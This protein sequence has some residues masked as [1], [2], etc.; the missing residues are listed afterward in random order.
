MPAS[1]KATATRATAAPGRDIGARGS[2]GTQRSQVRQALRSPSAAERPGEDM[3]ADSRRFDP[4]RQT[5]LGT[6]HLASVYFYTHDYDLGPEETRVLTEVADALVA[7]IDWPAFQRH[8]IRPILRGRVE[9]HADIRPARDPD[10][11]DLAR[12]RALETGRYLVGRM[13]IA[14][15]P[16]AIVPELDIVGKGTL[17]CRLDERCRALEPEALAATR[18]ADV[19]A[20][21]SAPPGG[22]PTVLPEAGE[23]L[24]VGLAAEWREVVEMMRRE[25]FTDDMI[26]ALVRE[27]GSLD[28]ADDILGLINVFRDFL[29][30]AADL[31]SV[32]GALVSLLTAWDKALI[33]KQ[34]VLAPIS[35][36]GVAY[37]VTAWA[38]DRAHPVDLPASDEAEIRAMGKPHYLDDAREIWSNSASRG[39]LAF[40]AFYAEANKTFQDYRRARGREAS[41]LPVA[42]FKALIRGMFGNDP[43][44]MACSFFDSMV[45][46]AAFLP[47]SREEEYKLRVS[48]EFPN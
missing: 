13:E 23:G 35:F 22:P 19:Y 48:C 21:I 33:G 25:G 20:E 4:R 40:A 2:S 11:E 46:D 1:V 30:F 15:G 6:N 10:N 36:K 7:G 38:F 32:A 37:G 45:E 29:P 5:G 43:P 34:Y 31:I 42:P 41:S 47:P 3:K 39:A 27:R 28:I 9:G 14:A 16:G 12:R 8:V 26:L 17:D 44:T 18:R 24:P